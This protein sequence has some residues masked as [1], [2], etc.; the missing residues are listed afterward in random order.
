MHS[1]D[2]RAAYKREPSRGSSFAQQQEQQLLEMEQPS[3]STQASAT[4]DPP[5]DSSP[6]SVLVSTLPILV[7]IGLFH[8]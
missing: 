3:T 7:M 1:N 5:P 4:Q 2:P 6:D 8:K